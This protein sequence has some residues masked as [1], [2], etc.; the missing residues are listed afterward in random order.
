MAAS[1]AKKIG[2]ASLIMMGS[3]FLSRVIGLFREMVIS[4]IGGASWAVDAYQIAFVIPEILN[5]VL[6]S[7]F[8]SI[9][10]IP[11]FS[12]YLSEGNE[13]EGWRVFSIIMTLFS[14]TLVLLIC[15]L[16]AGARDLVLIVAPQVKNPAVI[17]GA[18]RMTRIILPAQLFFFM[19][20]LFMAVQFAKGRFLFPAVAP[21]VYNLG[22]I[23]GGYFL[24]PFIG[25][26]GFSW[27]MI[28]GAFVGNFL[29]QYMGAK[30]AGMRFKPIVAIHHP[31]L[32]TY[33]KLTLPLMIG[34]SV[35]FSTEFLM[36][37]FGSSLAEGSIAKLNYAYRVMLM[38]A[39][40]FG[41][42]VGAATYPFLS[43]LA[44][45]GQHE[46][47]AGLLANTLKAISVVIPFSVLF[48]VLRTELIQTLFQ[49]GKFDAADT[50]A[51]A[52]ALFFL[53]IGA[54]AFTAQSV[55]SRGFYALQN[56]LYPTLVNTLAM[57]GCLPLF[58]LGTRFMGI[59][60][61]ALAASMAAILQTL[62]LYI[63]WTRKHPG[64]T[65]SS[66]AGFYLKVILVSAGIGALL[67][68]FNRYVLR[69]CAPPTLWGNL[70]V[71]LATGMIFLVMLMGAAYL[72]KL[73]EVRE[74]VER[75]L[76]KMRLLPR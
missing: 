26:E 15:I 20:G 42:A 65:K 13:S 60:G 62:I 16:M 52:S 55:V 4:H 76:K 47:M 32:L 53:L 46:E 5:H 41:Q 28:G 68:C 14:L 21:L 3:V 18:V 17:E 67:E 8:L 2:I 33:M 51:T 36:K 19:G 7:G 59:N 9:T 72:F 11:I 71:S 66:L 44:S 64:K 34:L 29:I 49:H 38:L 48:M 63:L 45:A 58:Y 56:T 61:L 37:F 74:A 25:M 1:Q 69:A 35:T 70:M 31:E 22:I 6:A 73:D 23:V 57:I 50:Q 39:G 12:K 24:S 75:V 30:K 27:G 40:F 54:V 43:R 10:F